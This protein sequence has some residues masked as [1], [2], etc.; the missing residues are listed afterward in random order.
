MKFVNLQYMLPYC[1]VLMKNQFCC[2]L[3]TFVCSKNDSKH[4]FRRAKITNFMYDHYVI[5]CDIYKHRYKSSLQPPWMAA[6]SY[7][8]PT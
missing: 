6:L 4:I 5:L 3:C 2:D 8:R 7:S 1:F